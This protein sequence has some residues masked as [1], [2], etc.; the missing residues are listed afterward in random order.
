MILRARESEQRGG[1]EERSGLAHARY[2]SLSDSL[3]KGELKYVPNGEVRE[4]RN[5][6][7]HKSHSTRDVFSEGA[8]GDQRSASSWRRGSGP[9]VE[10]P[11]TLPRDGR[12]PSR[13]YYRPVA[14]SRSYADWDDQGHA[15]FPNALRR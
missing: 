12:G 9:L 3:R 11:P 8:W 14:K 7:F 6:A 5:G 10:F 1:Y 13:D 15:G 2:G 4:S